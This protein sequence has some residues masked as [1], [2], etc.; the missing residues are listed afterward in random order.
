MKKF[1]A[2]LLVLAMFVSISACQTS[3][4]PT[5]TEPN[6]QPSAEQTPQ[7]DASPEAVVNTPPS[8][9]PVTAVEGTLTV[10]SRGEPTCL[11]PQMQND[12]PSTFA[13]FQLYETLLYKDS[14]TG[15]FKPMLAESWE[16]IDERTIR[17]GSAENFV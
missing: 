4:E 13:V 2:L 16:Q 7:V 14:A 3:N 15:E 10:A 1:L 17:F 11:D 9:M 5:T 6:V 8:G 12:Q